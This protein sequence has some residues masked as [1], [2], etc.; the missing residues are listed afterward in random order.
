M[1][2]AEARQRAHLGT[3]VVDHFTYTICSDG[4]LAEGVSHEAASFAGHLG[5]GRLICIYDDN[6]V[7]IDGMTDIWLSDDPVAR[8]TAYGWH[9]VNLGEIGNDLD[10]LEEAILAAKEVTDKPSG[11]VCQ[12]GF[13]TPAS[14]ACR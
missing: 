4:D 2:M 6:R 3:D 8:F 7:S 9:V 5:L 13:A 1:A 10:A 14:T 12:Y 11:W